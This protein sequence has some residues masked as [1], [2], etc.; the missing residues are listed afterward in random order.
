MSMGTLGHGMGLLMHISIN[1]TIPV[2]LNIREDLATVILTVIH[3]PVEVRPTDAGQ[4][5]AQAVVASFVHNNKHPSHN[6]IRSPH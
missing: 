1:G 3:H 5:I 2:Q 4:V 6:P